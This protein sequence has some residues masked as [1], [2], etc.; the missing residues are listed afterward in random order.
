MALQSICKAV[1][2]TISLHAKILENVEL[3]EEFICS[4]ESTLQTNKNP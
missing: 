2:S 3:V 1:P 4:H